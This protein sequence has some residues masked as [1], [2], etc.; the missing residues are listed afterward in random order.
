MNNSHYLENIDDLIH[1]QSIN[2]V[3]RIA[4]E[5]YLEMVDYLEAEKAKINSKKLFNDLENHFSQKILDHN[6]AHKDFKKLDEQ[7]DENM[8]PD[9]VLYGYDCG[10]ALD[11]PDFEYDNGV[12]DCDDETMPFMVQVYKNTTKQMRS[13]IYSKLLNNWMDNMKIELQ[14]EKLIV[15]RLQEKQ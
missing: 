1:G 8:H 4:H 10:E 2:L 6:I 7:Y 15:I 5:M 3:D 9:L 12:D 13:D 11:E 14:Q